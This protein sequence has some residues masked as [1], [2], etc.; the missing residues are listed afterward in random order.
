MLIKL[1]SED[2]Y[3]WF[4]SLDTCWDLFYEPENIQILHVFELKVFPIVVGSKVYTC[5][6]HEFH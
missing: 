3:M 6:L 4:K 2:M 5:P 1:W